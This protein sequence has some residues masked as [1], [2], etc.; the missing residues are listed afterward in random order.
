MRQG[1]DE[2]G[3]RELGPVHL[4]VDGDEV[5]AAVYRL[6]ALGMLGNLKRRMQLAG[7]TQLSDY[8]RKAN[9]VVIMCASIGSPAGA[10]SDLNKVHIIVPPPT[11]QEVVVPTKGHTLLVGF[12]VQHFLQSDA[13]IPYTSGY[14]EKAEYIHVHPDDTEFNSLGPLGYLDYGYAVDERYLS[15]WLDDDNNY[16]PPLYDGFPDPTN[17][18]WLVLGNMEPGDSN[19]VFVPEDKYYTVLT[20][21]KFD[22]RTL[23]IN[24]QFSVIRPLLGET[25][26]M[27]D[28]ELAEGWSYAYDPVYLSGGCGATINDFWEE[29]T[30]GPTSGTSNL[31]WAKAL[32]EHIYNQPGYEWE[33][34][35]KNNITEPTPIEWLAPEMYYSGGW[36]P[37]TPVGC[38]QTSPHPPGPMGLLDAERRAAWFAPVNAFVQ[39]TIEQVNEYLLDR[40][41]SPSFGPYDR[42]F[43]EMLPWW[44]STP[45]LNREEIQLSDIYM[46]Y[47]ESERSSFYRQGGLELNRSPDAKHPFV[48]HDRWIADP[49]NGGFA[50]RKLLEEYHGDSMLF[51]MPGD[52]EPR[53]E[54]SQRIHDK[55]FQD[56][57]V[58]VETIDFEPGIAAGEIETLNLRTGQSNVYGESQG[59][60]RQGFASPA[61]DDTESFN[62]SRTTTKTAHIQTSFG[63]PLNVPPGLHKV[64]IRAP[65]GKVR[66]TVLVIG[67]SIWQGYHT[68]EQEFSDPFTGEVGIRVGAM[69][70]HEQPAQMVAWD[71]Q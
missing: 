68:F 8:V 40:A 48:F 29:F 43:Y 7:I 46:H 34:G 55:V 52:D 10:A 63:L 22:T 44:H 2:L 57:D 64:K 37:S 39:A 27:P 59:P 28:Y 17:T 61:G 58:F 18:R 20:L 51:A 6:E 65:R 50:G 14:P 69:L 19:D 71:L 23:K 47:D 13:D 5:E 53:F 35:W 60:V 11:T 38:Q 26:P 25:W 70:D 15:G 42:S 67:D 33:V 24:R 30:Y 45:G 16:Y 32:N 54:Y 3:G 31:A 56:A 1:E 49:D 9:G 66:V 4:T 36:E 12:I 41:Y 62:F 21:A